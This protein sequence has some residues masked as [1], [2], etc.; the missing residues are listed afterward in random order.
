MDLVWK[1]N[2]GLSLDWEIP[3]RYPVLDGEGR[4]VN[5]CGTGSKSCG[6]S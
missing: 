1:M 6:T 4:K 2:P 5:E 3:Y